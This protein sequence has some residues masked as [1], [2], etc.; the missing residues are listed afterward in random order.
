MTGWGDLA[1]RAQQLSPASRITFQ[2]FLVRR[3]GPFG[4]RGWAGPR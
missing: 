3:L 2:D 1:A 4:R